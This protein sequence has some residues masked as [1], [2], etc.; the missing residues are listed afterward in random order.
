MTDSI[1]ASIT[2]ENDLEAFLGT[3]QLAGT[4]FVAEKRNVTLVDR[5]GPAGKAQGLHATSEYYVN[6]HLLTSEQLKLTLEQQKLHQDDLNIPKRPKWDKKTTKEQLQRAE[7]DAFLIW[8]R[9]MAR[10]EEENGLLLT[11]YERNIEIWRQLWRVIE[12]S[13]L[14][15]QIVDARNPFLFH[16]TDLEKYVDEVANRRED[17]VGKRN[18]LLVNKADFLTLEQ[19]KQW[20]STFDRMGIRFVFFSAALATVEQLDLEQEEISSQDSSEEQ[21]VTRPISHRRMQQ[22]ELEKTKRQE[23]QT[24]HDEDDEL[25][26]TIQQTGTR[27]TMYVHRHAQHGEQVKNS[28]A[29]LS[30]P[31]LLSLFERELQDMKAP[32]DVQMVI[33]MVGYPNVGKS[34]TINAL[35]GAKRVSVSATPG[36][37]KHFQTLPLQL[38]DDHTVTLCDCP[39]LVFPTFA[40][41]KAD[42]VTQGI[43]PV[44]Q[45]REHVGPVALLCSRVPRS[46]LEWTYGIRIKSKGE[47]EETFCTPEEFLQSYACTFFTR[48]FSRGD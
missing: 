21:E 41:T 11:P 38:S 46:V 13:H 35:L 29:I 5:L 32:E 27:N 23:R 2:Q 17:G 18:L 34:S 8:R 3:A 16:S 45:L 9:V 40:T 28:T 4:T 15:V 31:E 42:L 1:M 22:L 44:D 39:G 26:V 36:K 30:A 37:T 47:K 25:P 12:R 19:R 20:A 10:L 14:I 6:P 43:L 33:G 7:K 24:I 48:F